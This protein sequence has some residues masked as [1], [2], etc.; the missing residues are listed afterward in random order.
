[1]RRYGGLPTRGYDGAMPGVDQVVVSTSNA[2]LKQLRA[3]VAGNARLSAGLVA[4]EG[5]HLIEEALRSRIPLRAVFIADDR[6]PPGWLGGVG[7]EI[8]RVAATILTSIVETRTPQ[9]IAALIAPRVWR[10]EDTLGP[11]GC[12]PL[13]LV[14]ADLQDPGNVGTLLRSAEAFGATGAIL[15]SATANPWSGKAL[16][17]SAGSVFRL[18]TVRVADASEMR[19]ILGSVRPL[20]AVGSR[21]LS[22]TTRPQPIEEIDLSMPVALMLGNEGTGLGPAWVR[23]ADACVTIPCTGAVESLNAAVAGAVLLYEAQQ[24]RARRRDDSGEHRTA[25][26]N[27]AKPDFRDGAPAR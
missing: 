9:G 1:M 15:S 20:A 10:A 23:A 7:I 13:V 25:D 19:A 2:R 12:R 24:Q 17:A 26:R 14:L 5:E 27:A 16:R 21:S 8:I 3:A 6:E 4:I 11:P 18:P 22:A